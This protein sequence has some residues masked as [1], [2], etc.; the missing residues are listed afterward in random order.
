MCYNFNISNRMPGRR[1]IYAKKCSSNEADC[2]EDE[3]EKSDTG[4]RVVG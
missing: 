2:R 1:D 3:S 4:C